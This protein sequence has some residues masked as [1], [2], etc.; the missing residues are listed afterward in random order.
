MVYKKYVSPIDNKTTYSFKIY[1]ISE[2][3]SSNE[4]YNLVYE[5]IG[6]EWNE[7][8]FFNTEKSNPTDARELES[9]DMVYNRL[10][11]HS[12]LGFTEVITTSIVCSGSSICSGPHGCD[13]F[14]CPTGECIRTT[15]T[16]VYTGI[17]DSGSGFNGNPSDPGS[18]N[19]NGGGGGGEGN[20]IFIPN[21]Y[22]GDADPN[23]V[24][25]M[26]AGQV[27][28]FTNTLPTNL[29]SLISNY[30]FVYP[31]IVDFCR[32]NGN[33]VSTRNTQKIT[34]ALNNFYNFQ[35]NT[36]YNNL[37]NVNIDRFNFWAF[38]TFLNNNPQDV[39]NTKINNIK[40]FIQS[41]DFETA[42]P[43]VDYL[44]ENKDDEEAIDFMNYINLNNLTSQDAK[45]YIISNIIVKKIDDSALDECSKGILNSLKNLQQENI[46]KIFQRFET[47]NKP[48]SVTFNQ[49]P[50]LVKP[51]TN[52]PVYGL[53]SPTT[54]PQQNIN[55]SLNSNF[56]KNNGATKLG[57]ATVI[58]H[59]MMHAIIFSVISNGN[60]QNTDYDN[61][62]VIWDA[63]VDGVFNGDANDTQHAYI[64]NNWANYLGVGL[65]EY[66]TG[67]PVPSGQDPDQ[68][69]KDLAFSGLI[70]S[71]N[72][73]TQLGITPSDRARIVF[74]KIAEMNNTISNNIVPSNNPPCN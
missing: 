50:N 57:K 21:P 27:A 4:Y 25:F 29:Q 51:F 49:V 17:Q 10:S 69:Y 48:F 8:I 26:L 2:S 70:D 9:S 30:N 33:S 45:D 43:I 63:Y 6:T 12:A 55:I 38:Y 42:N 20:G 18:G 7:I 64:A 11:S 56:F 13:G 5:K 19:A 59:E 46:A 72:S 3:L 35:L 32:N 47:P 53:A 65:Q 66:I 36:S 58:L 54:I 40:N 41:T 22:E 61:F 31:Y 44:Y 34:T 73:N 52:I 67:T 74:R 15:V 37:T 71:N 1:P 16:Y 23:N 60:F 28:S 62:P 24:G 68:I 39:N 14:A